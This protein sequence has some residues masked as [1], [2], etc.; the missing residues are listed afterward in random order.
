MRDELGNGKPNS[1]GDGMKATELLKFGN[2]RIALSLC[3]I[4]GAI[5][6][7]AQQLILR[8]FIHNILNY[9]IEI[10]VKVFAVSFQKQ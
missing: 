2:D 8:L 4:S 6:I 7:Y 10:N 9:L 3:L 1:S 5:N